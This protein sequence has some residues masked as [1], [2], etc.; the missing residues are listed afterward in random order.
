MELLPYTAASVELMQV[1]PNP[2]KLISTALRITMKADLDSD[3]PKVNHKLCKYLLDA[4]HT[5]LLEHVVYTFLLK[6]VSRSFLAQI[7]RHRMASYTSG[8]QHYQDYSEYPCVV[9]PVFIEDESAKAFMN[10]SLTNSFEE[11]SYLIR[12]HGVPV[13]EARQIL[14]NA[15]AVNILW[16]INARSLVNFL[17]L[18]LCYRNVDEMQMFAERVL[19]WARQH[20]P[21]LFDNVG[22]QCF[23]DK[24]K[25][26]KMICNRGPWK[27]PPIQPKRTSDEGAEDHH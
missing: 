22:P 1:T 9:H 5:S 19:S 7:T 13:Y 15:A 21:A 8:S 18:R 27:L 23:M 26:G 2:E 12:E 17:K 20:F 25:Q 4:E 10:I 3:I 16:T 24:C 6:N 14:P 11:Y